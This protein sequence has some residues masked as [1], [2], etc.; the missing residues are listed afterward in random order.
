MS[1]RKKGKGLSIFF[2]KN[3]IVNKSMKQL[4]FKDT[5]IPNDNYFKENT[6]SGRGEILGR[7]RETS[8]ERKEPPR[9][10]RGLGRK[11]PSAGLT[12]LVL[13]LPNTH[14]HPLALFTWENTSA[15]GQGR[16]PPP[17]QPSALIP[18]KAP[19]SPPHS[20]SRPSHPGTCPALAFIH[21]EDDALVSILEKLLHHLGEP[22][23]NVFSTTACFQL[24]LYPWGTPRFFSTLAP[25][26]YSTS[27]FP[28][29]F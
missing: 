16:C 4:T 25:N 3:V 6:L 2:K 29:F 19:L 21:F 5:P 9:G 10:R 8:G 13:C 1:W 7:R 17:P 12:C 27:N 15:P 20:P 23:G 24:V 14:P 28:R 11:Q 26:N 22:S 18:E